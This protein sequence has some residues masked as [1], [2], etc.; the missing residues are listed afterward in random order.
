M[1]NHMEGWGP[2]WG[3]FAA[4]HLLW[5]M[6]A[7]VALVVLLR[8]LT[9]RDGQQKTPPADRSLDILRDR[10]A[11]GEIDAAEF[12]ARRRTLGE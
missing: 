5:W 2:G 11:R 10:F 4:G 1:W 3:W 12:E 6:I 7:I 8:W 9:Q